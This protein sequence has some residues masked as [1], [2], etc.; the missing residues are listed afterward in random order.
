MCQCIHHDGHNRIPPYLGSRWIQNQPSTAFL[1]KPETFHKSPLVR[2]DLC[3]VVISPETGDVTELGTRQTRRLSIG[4]PLLGAGQVVHRLRARQ[5]AGSEELLI[6][7]FAR[8]PPKLKTRESIRYNYMSRK[9]WLAAQPG[10]LTAFPAEPALIAGYLQ[11][12]SPPIHETRNGGFHVDQEASTPSGTRP[13]SFATL[14]RFLAGL[15][16]LHREA[17]ID[18]P[19]KHPE[20]VAVWRA[21]R[22]GLQMARLGLPVI[23]ATVDALP[24]SVEGKRD[25][26]LLLLAYALMARRSELVALNDSSLE[27]HTDE[28]MTVRFL[29]TKTKAEAENYLPP[30]ITE[31]VEDWLKVRPTSG[32]ALFIRLDRAGDGERLSPGSVADVMRRALRSTDADLEVERIGSHSARIGASYDLALSG[33]SDSA[34]MRDAGWKTPHMVGGLYTWRKSA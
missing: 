18:D 15:A 34:I 24:S 27:R 23:W 1:Y 4:K 30:D 28:S 14:Q 5:F 25:R 21:L 8:P 17:S 19:T 31:I 13:L 12:H 29:R 16:T 33:A 22:R 26:A 32:P 11:A 20:V 7:Y 9:R 10:H 2:V 3:T 6:Q